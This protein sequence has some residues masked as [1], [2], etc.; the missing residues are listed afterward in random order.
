MMNETFVDYEVFGGMSEEEDRKAF[1][2]SLNYSLIRDYF[3]NDMAC[4]CDACTL[5]THSQLMTR[6]INIKGTKVEEE[7]LVDS[8][9]DSG[10]ECSA[11]RQWCTKGQYKDEQITKH[12]RSPA[13]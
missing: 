9:R 4:P 3:E 10:K 13:I 1:F 7:L 11:F 2:E 8:C 6:E 5:S 12:L